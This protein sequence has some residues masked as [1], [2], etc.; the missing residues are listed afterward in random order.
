M[1][2]AKQ[3]KL[4]INSVVCGD[5][6]SVLP[7][8]PKASID[9]VMFSP[10]YWGLR[11]YKVKK[12]PAMFAKAGLGLEP[13]PQ[14]YIERMVVLCRLLK[15]VLK[16]SGSMYLNLGDTYCGG[17]VHKAKHKNPGLSKSAKTMSELEPQ[18]LHG[19]MD[20]KWLQ[21]KQKLMMP[22]RVAIALQ[23]DGWI[24]RNDIIWH[25][26]NHMPSSVKDRLTSS[27]EH[28]FHFVKARRYFYDLDAIR[29]PHKR[30]T[31]Q[32]E[33]DYQRMMGSRLE[34]NGKT[35]EGLGRKAFVSRDPLGKNPGDTISFPTDLAGNKIVD[36]GLPAPK[37]FKCERCGNQTQDYFYAPDWNKVI[38]KEWRKSELCFNCY[39]ELRVTTKHDLAVGRLG[40]F[41]YTDPLHMK[42]EHPRGKNPGDVIRPYSVQPRLREFV[43]YR[44]LPSL[45]EIAKYLS[46]WRKKRGF[47]IEQVETKLESQAP[48]H[49]FNAESYPTKE[50]WLRVKQLLDFDDKYDRQ[51]L[52]VFFRPA[53]KQ[54]YP[55]GKNPADVLE[56]ESKYAES[57]YGQT[58]QG[59]IREQTI[60]KRR[61]QSREE[62][63]RLFPNNPKKQQEYINFI[64]DHDTHPRG[65]NP[66]D[67]VTIERGF[68]GGR[69]EVTE[70]WLNDNCPHCGRTYR[71][72]FGVQSGK[73]RFIPC[74]PKGINPSDFW[75][76]NT[77]PFPQAHFAVYPVEICRLPILSSCP[78]QI[79]VA[80]GKPRTRITKRLE[81][82]TQQWGKR[83]SKPWFK[84][85]R[86]MPQKVIY[87]SI[88]ETVG[89]SDCGC[90][91]GFQAGIVLDPMCGSGT[92]LIAAHKLGR[93]WIGIDLNPS[94]VE[95]AKK[96]IE[97]E[98]SQWL[99]TFMEEN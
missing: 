67:V 80:C 51:M 63:K 76:I 86:E 10:P 56:Y 97:R 19:M 50:D 42:A 35:S 4:P 70:E 22:A 15:R 98:C 5:A 79:C 85:K 32:A 24:L 88:N 57:E 53:E 17:G 47:T 8:F 9:M 84:D 45:K 18:R 89:F 13:H 48:H 58:L 81:K 87:E 2:V 14:Q 93:R 75:S 39:K 41:A 46:F 28:I 74:D 62:A 25:K 1:L 34:Y 7:T 33:R 49:W 68:K 26:P 29:Q 27:Y 96:R 55:L 20:N 6:F 91:K 52:E 31:Y 11:D 37:R 71:R 36:K 23:Q 92:T 21:P 73:T 30:G 16:K 78:A 60:V 59:F 77:K 83:K 38:P 44:N 61:Q 94:Y 43:E 90:N 99:S 82:F 54:D 66:A 64:H 69:I 3:A 72:H 65:K 40:N 95:M 12:V